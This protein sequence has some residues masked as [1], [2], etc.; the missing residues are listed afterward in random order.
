[1]RECCGRPPDCFQMTLHEPERG[2]KR[3][4]LRKLNLFD[5]KARQRRDAGRVLKN[6]WQKAIAARLEGVARVKIHEAH[7]PSV[8][9]HA[10]IT[11]DLGVFRDFRSDM[12]TQPCAGSA[13]FLD[14]SIREV[15]L[16]GGVIK[17]AVDRHGDAL[18]DVFWH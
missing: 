1:M 16:R 4:G 10:G 2:F 5:P 12:F 6:T 14:A 15:A 8:D 7:C 9:L 11:N 18:N 13:D 17:C 3:N